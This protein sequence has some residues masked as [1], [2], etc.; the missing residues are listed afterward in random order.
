[1]SAKARVVVVSGVVVATGW[2]VDVVVWATV[3][4]VVAIE[5]SLLD[6]PQAVRISAKARAGAAARRFDR[7]AIV[8]DTFH[9]TMWKSCLHSTPGTG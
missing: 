2:L 9:C 4:E 1:A 6:D 3:V 5:V 7:E 8:R